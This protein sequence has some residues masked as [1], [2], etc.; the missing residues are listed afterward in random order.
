MKNQ[1]LK[2]TTLNSWGKVLFAQRA[3]GMVVLLFY[4]SPL[5]AQAHAQGANAQRAVGMAQTTDQ[6]P[7]N[8]FL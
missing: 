4:S 1:Q 7:E 5:Y 3:V 2:R 6:L 8:S